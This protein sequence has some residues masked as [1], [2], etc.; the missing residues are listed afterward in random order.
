LVI[1]PIIDL[2]PANRFGLYDKGLTVRSYVEL[3]EQATIDTLAEWGISGV[4]TENP[5]VWEYRKGGDEGMER[6]I[7][8]LGVHLRRNVTSYGVGLNIKTD[9][10]WFDRIVACGLIGKGVT[11]MVQLGREQGIWRRKERLGRKW[12]MEREQKELEG[13]EVN[14]EQRRKH[15]TALRKRLKPCVVG[16]TWARSFARGLFGEEGDTRVRKITLADLGAAIEAR[17]E[18]DVD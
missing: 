5:G 1:Y 13:E 8:A 7:A 17:R 15:G 2:K 18:E 3:L 4:R 11:S 6:K 12:A 9:L 14:E 16:R 10:T